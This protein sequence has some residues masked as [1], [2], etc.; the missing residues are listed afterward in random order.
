[1]KPYYADFGD[2]DWKAYVFGMRELAR[3]LMPAVMKRVSLGRSAARLLDVGG[4]H[5]LYTLECCQRST[6]LR[7][8]IMDFAQPLRWTE[9]FIQEAGLGDR[10]HTM[11]GDF[12]EAD[13]PG[14]QDIILLFNVIHGLTEEQNGLL[15]G[16]L[17][18]ALARDGR[19]YVLDQMTGRAHR[20][21]LGK[22]MPLMVGLNLLNE[23]G[24]KAYAVEDVKRW[25]A[26][27]RRVKKRN[28]GVPGVTLVEI[29]N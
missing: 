8:M 2:R 29:A 23:I 6:Q 3:F 17:M 21:A 26:G 11:P 7:A 5:G 25:C 14:D 12:L 15:I 28:L 20:S 22:V 9:Q 4:S 18:R 10:V 24:G 13:I 16:R 19:M 27:A 1:M